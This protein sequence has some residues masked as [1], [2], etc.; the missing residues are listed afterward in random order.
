MAKAIEIAKGLHFVGALDPELRVFD[1]VMESPRGTSYNSYV[2]EGEAGV[3]V[4]EAC[5]AGFEEQWI[6]RIRD[7]VDPGRITHIFLNHTEPDHAGA[8]GALLA[9]APQ[10]KVYA[11]RAAN[12]NI[13]QILNAP[14]PG[15]VMA[16]GQSFDLGGITLEVIDAP[17]LHWPDSLFL[18]CKELSA[19][20]TC[21]VFGFHYVGDSIFADEAN[22]ELLEYRRYYFDAIFSPF[23]EYV[24]S[25]LEKIDGLPIRYLLT[26]HGPIY[27]AEEEARAAMDL[28]RGWAQE[29]IDA[30]DPRAVFVGYA[31]A[32]GYT[33]MAAVAIAQEVESAGLRAVL[34]DIGEDPA[35]AAK[36]ASGC[37][38]LAV[39]TSTLNRDALPPVW[40][41]LSELS[42]IRMRKRPAIA[43]GSFGWSGEAVAN[44]KARMEQIGM[45]VVAD[46]KWKLKPTDEDIE[47]VK[48]AAK[49]LMA[50]IEG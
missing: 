48:D 20:F 34:F 46:M 36:A 19:L 42:A 26:S 14:F 17:F 29:T 50:A 8:L 5:K 35:G 25:A 16:G 33:R 28:Y 12:M 49:Q 38:A 9:V 31:S 37:A 39:G 47:K 41:F 27:R 45:K 22:V 13:A 30:F 21:D 3:A 23:S 15:N 6:G 44:I 7:C 10:A 32:Y 18:W 43:F 40:A 1:V 4:I 2:L 24:I 11:S